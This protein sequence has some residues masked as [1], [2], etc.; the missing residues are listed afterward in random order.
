LR[1]IAWQPGGSGRIALGDA[2]G[3][4]IVVEI[5]ESS[6]DIMTEY[7]VHSEAVNRLAFSPHHPSWL[8][9][10][11]DDG[12]VIVNDISENSTVYS[13]S[14]HRDVVR[15][16]AWNPAED[17]VLRSCG[18]DSQLLCHSILRPVEES[19]SASMET[20]NIEQ[21]AN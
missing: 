17:G 1:S 7:G 15:G 18:L 5:G 16:L 8:A 20:D 19:G 9:S 10:A 3:Q 21:K 11:S 12:T 4:I 14:K 13:S 2:R 6:C